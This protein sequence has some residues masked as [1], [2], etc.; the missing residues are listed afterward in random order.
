MYL[1]LKFP[2]IFLIVLLES[3]KSVEPKTSKNND[4]DSV[5]LE[6]YEDESYNDLLVNSER[7]RP[8]KD[9]KMMTPYEL[10]FSGPEAASDSYLLS[11]D[12]LNKKEDHFQTFLLWLK[13]NVI[14]NKP[15]KYQLIMDILRSRIYVRYALEEYNRKLF[16]RLMKALTIERKPQLNWQNIWDQWVKYDNKRQSHKNQETESSGKTSIDSFISDIVRKNAKDPLG[17]M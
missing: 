16:V 1:T 6:T 4:S 14:A 15:D 13:Y 7:V 17:I 5:V 9:R 11:K 8:K 12:H 10:L 3:F 2:L